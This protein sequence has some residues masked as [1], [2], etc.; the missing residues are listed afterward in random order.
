MSS[1]LHVRRVVVFLYA[2]SRHLLH[3]LT[4]M[5]RKASAGLGIC[6]AMVPESYQHAPHN[7]N[8]DDAEK[9]TTY[10]TTHAVNMQ[11]PTPMPTRHMPKLWKRTHC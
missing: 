7:T 10:A 8:A 3:N 5:R 9:H 2:G 1:T 11:I 6:V 4:D